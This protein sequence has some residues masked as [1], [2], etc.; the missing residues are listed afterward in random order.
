MD[1]GVLGPVEVRAGGEQRAVGGGRERHVLATLLL[2]VGRPT[3]AARLI[4][5]LWDE[6]PPSAKAQ[7]HNTISR[8]RRA[9]GRDDLIVTRA[10]G[11]EL[12][13]DEHDT[14]DLL[15]FRGLV[16]EG[17]RAGAVGDQATAAE[18]LGKR[19]R[20]GGDRRSPTSR[21]SW[22]RPPD[23]P[24]TRNGWRPP[25]RGSPRSSSSVGTPTSSAL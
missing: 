6:P 5:A 7:L 18:R 16:A 9:V 2:G 21:T 17:L 22:P 25:R 3:S 23:M 10:A 1:F 11:Y 20:C 19:F 8:L 4:D 15:S 14:F 12:R 24:C 13:L